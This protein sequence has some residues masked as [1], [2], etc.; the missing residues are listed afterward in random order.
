MPSTAPWRRSS[1]QTLSSQSNPKN[2]LY[3]LVDDLRAEF[4]FTN[5]ELSLHTPTFDKF[6]RES[7]YF[8]LAFS[9]V[10]FCV[11]SR[12]SFLTGLRP[13]ATRSIHNDQLLRLG[14]DRFQP[15]RPG[16]TLFDAFHDAGFATATV[17]KI[18]HFAE[19][20]PAVDFKEE[21]DTHDLL[22]QPCDR[23]T[24]KNVEQPS[25]SSAR[26]FGFPKAC[27][28]PFGS[29][30]DQRVVAWAYRF[31]RHL[32]QLQ[33]QPWCA[34]TLS[35]I[36]DSSLFSMIVTPVYTIMP[37]QAAGDRLPE[38]TQPVPI[39]TRVPQEATVG[40][41]YGCCDCVET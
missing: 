39:P 12:A 11:P 40:Q 8:G 29:F 9:Q 1:D 31:L 30:V 2:V 20:H 14:A 3:V 4:G 5:P 13:E 32:V 15:L 28:L 37:R 19:S 24:A 7:M 34:T 38:A 25:V 36:N 18:F 21:K 16:W 27:D 6:S 41:L 26:S 23:P 17:G 35:A 33:Q 22:G 10:A